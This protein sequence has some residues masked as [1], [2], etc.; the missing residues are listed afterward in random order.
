[1]NEDQKRAEQIT[2]L[3][4]KAV[5]TITDPEKRAEAKTILESTHKKLAAMTASQDRPLRPSKRRIS[6][7]LE[8][9]R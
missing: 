4:T 8:Y 3:A 1:M 5:A 6:R 2:A 9:D 7:D